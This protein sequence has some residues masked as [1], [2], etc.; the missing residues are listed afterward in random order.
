MAFLYGEQQRRLSI[1]KI[2][3]KIFQADYTDI[4]RHHVRL[5]PTVSAYR[6]SFIY[7]VVTHLTR[8]CEKPIKQK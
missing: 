5:I 7:R 4:Q 8:N 3:D 2:K 6:T 1:L